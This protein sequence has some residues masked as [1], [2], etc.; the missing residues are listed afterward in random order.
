[1]G[2]AGADVYVGDAIEEWDGDLLAV[3]LR[4]ESLYHMGLSEDGRDATSSETVVQGDHGRLR[5]VL[6]G[7]DSE[8]FLATSNRDGRGDP[9]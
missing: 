2:I 9:A 3:S 8:I 5:D 4:G 7:P 1:M 6:V